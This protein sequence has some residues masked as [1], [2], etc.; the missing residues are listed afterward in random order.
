MLD[1]TGR[2][3]VNPN[4]PLDMGDF[5][6]L[7][8]REGSTPQDAA[9]NI[10]LNYP[11]EARDH[12]DNQWSRFNTGNSPEQYFSDPAHAALLAAASGMPPQASS[13]PSAQPAWNAN[14]PWN[15]PQ[16]VPTMAQTA[17]YQMA[18]F[19][20]SNSGTPAQ[21]LQA[22]L[23][24]DVYGD[25]KKVLQSLQGFD[26]SVELTL[27]PEARAQLQPYTP[28]GG[29]GGITSEESMQD[30]LDHNLV[31]DPAFQQIH[32]H[33]PNR[34][35]FVYKSLTGRDLKTD[36]D[37]HQKSLAGQA[38]I[39]V[40]YAS[41]ALTHGAKIDP[42]TGKWQVWQESMPD[43]NAPITPGQTPKPSTQL[44][45]ATPEQQA[46]LTKFYSNVTG[47]S[48]PTPQPANPA[49]SQ[50]NSLPVDLR[51]KATQKYAEM[52]AL[53]GHDL[54][55]DETS[56]MISQI[57]HSP[58]LGQRFMDHVAI[59]LAQA[60]MAPGS[61]I[62]IIRRGLTGLTDPKAVMQSGADTWAAFMDVLH[63][64]SLTSPED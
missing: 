44:G 49:L 43:P 52:K 63:K 53:T 15:G 55:P 25:T 4:V 28:Q 18:Q 34:G 27:R 24:P 51:N 40:Q 29:Y 37:L 54:T 64:G 32:A 33:D 21:N 2:V 5:A 57:V 23:A 8:G 9:S 14:V 19:P 41:N 26:P 12:L 42:E 39:G 48:L 50:I 36:L 35:A 38:K 47:H 7:Y 11:S 31:N 13:S 10:F 17:Q 6:R 22:Q 3:V 61:G 59:P 58:S 60:P 62:D 16:T 46:W 45:D 1:R 56:K 30:G 20:L